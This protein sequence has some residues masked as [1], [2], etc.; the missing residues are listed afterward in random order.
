MSER[1]VILGAG[2]AGLA[3]ATALHAEG[4]EVLVVNRS[5]VDPDR[6]P[7]GVPTAT[8]DITEPGLVGRLARGATA[9]YNATHAPYERQLELLPRLQQ[10]ALAG[11]RDTGARLVVL[12]TLYPYGPTG[13]E[14]MTEATPH[15][16]TSRKGRLRAEL[17]DRYLDSDVP[18]AI[19]RSADFFGPGVL[20][21][22]LGGTVFGPAL[23][24]RPVT[25]LGRT[26]LPHAYTYLGDVARGL[27]TLGRA[28]GATGRVWLLPTVP[29][30]STD[31]VLRLLEVEL[32]HPLTVAAMTELRPVGP[33]DATLMA[34]YEELFYQNQEP[35]IVDSSA[36]ERA[37]D[38]TP[39][40]L[41]T[42][43]RATVEWYRKLA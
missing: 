1:H 43:L 9:I 19:G 37:F 38:L 5:P 3:T 42:A 26:D 14:P 36:F 35:Q 31:E 23:A 41:P 7:A 33:F 28:E 29:A 18:V 4:H 12:D 22:T 27:A 40:P 25:V 39:T 2:P 10:A 13:G 16:A 34:E 15:R 8:G 30:V 11:A 20:N 32:G 24:G 21:S 17:T 6:L